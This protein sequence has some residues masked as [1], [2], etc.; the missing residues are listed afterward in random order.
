MT[1]RHSC[2]VKFWALLLRIRLPNKLLFVTN[3]HFAPESL[4]KS[5][6]MPLNCPATPTRSRAMASGQSDLQWKEKNDVD[7]RLS[8]ILR[9][10]RTLKMIAK[11]QT[12]RTYLMKAN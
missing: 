1:M 2:L 6:L 11:A 7:D 9:R 8:K 10:I 5:A 12:Y 3:G 4:S